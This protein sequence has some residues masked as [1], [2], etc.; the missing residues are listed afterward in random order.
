M[1]LLKLEEKQLQELAVKRGKAWQKFGEALVGYE[2]KL[3]SLKMELDHKIA[4]LP[5]KD[6]VKESEQ[7]LKE[8]K[9]LLRTILAERKS[10]TDKLEPVKTRLMQPEKDSKDA[11]INY[12]NAIKEVKAIREKEEREA[13]AVIE[14]KKEMIAKIKQAIVE[15]EYHMES[16][17][18]KFVYR[19]Y[20]QMLND[21][22][23]FENFDDAIESLEPISFKDINVF[24]KEQNFKLSKVDKKE[25]AKIWKEQTAEIEQLSVKYQAKAIE[26]LKDKKV[27]YRSEIANVKIAKEQLE[28]DRKEAE[29]KAKEEKQA[30]ELESKLNASKSE[31]LKP[32]SDIKA[33]KYGYEVDMEENVENSLQIWACF[34]ANLDILLPVMNISKWDNCGSGS[35]KKALSK[36]K[37]NDNSLT[38]SGITFKQTTKL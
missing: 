8:S 23:A 35:I 17:V 32:K 3:L 24:F 5:T 38:F 4:T 22:V 2:T 29:K 25:A 14:E 11:I 16:E 33:L 13:N 12:E 10:I 19:S 30:K 1:E 31:E 26:L 9:E 18:N 34:S 27:A 28:K 15:L 37:T 7:L 36:L 20:S 21:E 6:N